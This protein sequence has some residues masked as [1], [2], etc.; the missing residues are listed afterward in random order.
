MVNVIQCKKLRVHV[1]LIYG[2]HYPKKYELRCKYGLRHYCR[3]KMSSL[4]KSFFG[5]LKTDVDMER[6][7]Q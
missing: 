4:K 2:I 7:S 1:G 6:L 3:S 5:I